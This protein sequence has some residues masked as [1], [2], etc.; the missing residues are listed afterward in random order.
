MK[1]KEYL[2]N[3][4]EEIDSHLKKHMSFHNVELKKL[5]EAMEY[6]LLSG[7]KRLRPALALATCE[8][9]EQPRSNALPAAC[10]IEMIHTYSLIH[11]DLPCMDDDTYRRGKL[12]NH[13]VFG[14]AMA[15]LAGDALLTFAFQIMIEGLKEKK[16]KASTILNCIHELSLA[17]GPSGMVGG[18]SLDLLWENADLEKEKIEAIHSKKTGALLSASIKIGGMIGGASNKELIILDNY[19]R[20]LG[21]AFQIVDD[22][23]DIEGDK[24]NMGKSPGSD[25]QRGIRTYPQ[26]AGIQKA[27]NKA[28][29]LIGECN[30]ELSSLGKNTE[31]LHSI[32]DFVLE[33]DH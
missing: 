12:T 8:L 24:K 22:L 29:E 2:K 4:T 10:A 33:R 13:K 20:K 1:I 5:Y 11:D 31:V 15:V 3:T 27:R 32:A 17:A 19:G 25:I 7:G 30:T 21:L 16:V 14:E 18:Q 26:I 23:L 28:A 6:S 9:F